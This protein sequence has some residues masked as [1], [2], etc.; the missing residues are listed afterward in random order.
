MSGS[1]RTGRIV[2]L[3]EYNGICT[4]V[5]AQVSDAAWDR[6]LL[7]GATLLPAPDGSQ[8]PTPTEPMFRGCECGNCAGVATC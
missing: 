3:D 4:S 7:D 8:S 5:I 1:L 6:V 2:E